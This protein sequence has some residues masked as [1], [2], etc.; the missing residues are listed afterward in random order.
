MKERLAAFC[1]ITSLLCTPVLY[2]QTTPPVLTL[3]Q[4][5]FIKALC[6]TLLGSPNTPGEILAPGLTADRFCEA[7]VVDAFFLANW[8][9]LLAKHN[10]LTLVVTDNQTR[11]ITLEAKVASLEGGSPPP[12]PPPPPPSGT[13]LALGKVVTASSSASAFAASFVADGNGSTRWAS[14]AS[15]PQWVEIDLGAVFQIARVVLNWEAAFGSDY[16][17]QVSMDG[18]NWTQA[19][20]VV[21]G[22]GGL[23][24]RSFAPGAG[25]EAACSHRFS[26]G[27]VSP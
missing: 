4:Q 2:A 19:L 21:G 16:E 20:L 8:A 25:C 9:D 10:I 3:T 24:D 11:I 26:K 12:P 14:P 23:E 22:P 17:I 15:D 18:V 13:N 5:A 27:K 1:L 6:L 7:R